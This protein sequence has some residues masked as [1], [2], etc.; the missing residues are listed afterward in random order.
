MVN[1]LRRE[2]LEFQSINKSTITVTLEVVCDYYNRRWY[3]TCVA[4]VALQ[5]HLSINLDLFNPIDTH[6]LDM[7]R[8]TN[9]CT[10]K[11]VLGLHTKFSLRRTDNL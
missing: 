8:D 1:K 2:L 3:F 11:R 9:L 7:Q 10:N 4:R 6:K 5:H